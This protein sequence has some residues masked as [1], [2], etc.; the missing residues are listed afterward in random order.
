MNKSNVILCGFMGCGKSTVGKRLSKITGR[1]FVDMDYY[2]EEKSNMT[3][4]EIF[5]KYG[6]AYFRD[7]EYNTAVELAQKDNMI[8]SA[9]GG[10]LLFERNVQALSQTGTIVLLNVSLSTLRYRLRNDTKRPLLQRPDKNKAM[11]EMYEQRMPLYTRAADITVRGAKPPV[12]VCMDICK[13]LSIPMVKS[14]RTHT[15][16]QL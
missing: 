1:P 8:I 2:I 10:T 15:S 5:E 14:P 12:K 4:K 11:A 3:V 6:E 7:L 9:G 16:A 13:R